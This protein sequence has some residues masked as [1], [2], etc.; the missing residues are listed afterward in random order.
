MSLLIY[1]RALQHS[2]DVQA[3]NRSVRA[4]VRRAARVAASVIKEG[5]EIV[6]TIA[7]LLAILVAGLALDAWIWI[8]RLGH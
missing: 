5:R 8:P 1:G 7:G 3:L 4:T 6:L 2:R